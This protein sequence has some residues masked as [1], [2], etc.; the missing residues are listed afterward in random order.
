MQLEC[1]KLTRNSPYA[2]MTLAR[3][4]GNTVSCALPTAT[5]TIDTTAQICVTAHISAEQT[6]MTSCQR[7]IVVLAAHILER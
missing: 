6:H 7:A 1:T 4:T 2:C 3:L 5:S